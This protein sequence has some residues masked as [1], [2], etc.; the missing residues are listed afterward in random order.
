[1]KHGVTMGMRKAAVPI[2]MRKAGHVLLFAVVQS[3]HGFSLDTL[4][5]IEGLVTLYLSTINF[6]LSYAC[7][8]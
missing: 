5:Q 3:L 1:M 2:G 8:K 4:E 7:V 6:P